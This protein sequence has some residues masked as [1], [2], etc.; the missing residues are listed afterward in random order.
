MDQVKARRPWYTRGATLFVT[1]AA[2]VAL[3]PIGAV[4]TSD[5][6]GGL[7]DLVQKV[8]SLT[9]QTTANSSDI[10]TLKSQVA[11]L[12]TAEATQAA[13]IAALQQALAAETAARQAGDAATL[14]SANAHSD[15]GDAA[16]LASANAHS[17]AG[18]AAT[19]AAAK[20]YTDN[21]LLNLNTSGSDDDS[22]LQAAIAAET[23]RAK[24]AENGLQ[25][26]INNAV[27]AAQ[28][29]DSTI[30]ASAVHDGS[31]I[32]EL[33]IQSMVGTSPTYDAFRSNIALGF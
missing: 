3:L 21:A 12:Q 9:G 10:T 20:S 30:Y 1:G 8:E 29:A 24:G 33:N 13:Q 14:A 15:T 25:I 28:T 7:P 2:A 5:N 27:S 32:A 4:A 19:L 16:T 18:D 6:A 22:A 17:D 26:G 11:Q 31:V 23:T